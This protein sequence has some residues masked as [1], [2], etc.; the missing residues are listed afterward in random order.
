MSEE[1]VYEQADALQNLQRQT[2]KITLLASEW[3]SLAGGLSTLNRE[4]AINLSQ[5]QNVSV[6]LLVPEGACSDEDKKE[7]KR[8]DISIIEARKCVG[9]DPLVWL[10]HPPENHEIDVIVGHGVKLGSPVQLIK[11]LAQ[12]QNCKWVHVV[13]TVPENLSKHKDYNSA[14]LRGE[15]KHWDEVDL[16]KS[17]DLV[18]PVGPRIAKAYHSYLQ[19]CKKDEEFFE[20]VPGL[21]EREFGDLPAKQKPKEGEDDFIVLL[22]GRGDKEDFELKGYNIAVEAFANKQLKGKHYSLLF[23]GSPEGKQDEVRERLLK[24]GITEEQLTVREFVKSRKRMKELFCEVDMVIM[25]SKEEGFGLVALEALSAGLPILIG[26][27]SGFASAIKNIPL[28]EYS[29]VG[30]S[31]DPAKWA[32]AIKAVRNRH[33]V[34]LG[35]SETLKQ[36]YSEKYCWKKQCE[37]LVDRLLKM[38]Y[39]MNINEDV[40]TQRSEDQQLPSAS[41]KASYD[42]CS[43]HR[44]DTSDAEK[45]SAT[46]ENKQHIKK[47]GENLVKLFVSASV[48]EAGKQKL[49]EEMLALQVLTYAEFQDHSSDRERG[50]GAM[51]E[52]MMQNYGLL[53]KSVH[54]GSL[55]IIFDCQSLEGLDHLWSDYLFGHL[56]KMA[57]QFLLTS[58]MKEKL[59]LR[60]IGLKTTIEKGN[61]LQCRKVLLERSGMNINEDVKTQRSDQQLPSASSKASY[62]SCSLHRSDTSDAE[63]VSA[64]NENKQHIRKVGGMNINEDVKTQ[65]SDQQLPSASSKASYDSCSLHRSDTSDAEKVSATNENKQHIR[66]VGGTSASQTIAANDLVEQGPSVVPESVCQPVSKP[67]QQQPC[68]IEKDGV[69]SGRGK[70]EKVIEEGN[71][72]SPVCSQFGIEIMSEEEVYEQADAVQNPQRQTLKITLLANEWKSS[73]GSL[74]A[75]NR[76]L[77]INLSQIQ[78]VSVSLLVPE[79]TCNDEDKRE[80]E[81]FGISI[82]EARKCVD[83][84][85]LVWLRNPP[86]DHKID[87]IV[88]HGVKLGHQVQHIKAHPQ[89]QN[90]KYVQLAHTAPEDLSKYKGYDS[91]ISRGEKKHW[92]EVA[93]CK[94]A[95]FVVPVGPSFAKAYHSY[96]FLQ[97][98]DQDFFELIPGLFESEFRDLPAKQKP[99]EEKDD[100]IVLLCGRGDKEDFEVKEYKIAVEAFANRRLK[101]KHYSLLFVGSPKGKQDEVRKRLLKYGITEEQLTVRELVKSRE[102]M[103][104]LFCEVD[105]LIMPSKKDGFSLI[106]LEALSAGLP[107]LVGSN[108]GFAKAM[109]NIPFGKYSTVANSDDPARWAEAIEDVRDRHGVVLAESETLKE[110]YSKKYCWKKQCEELVARLW[111]MV[112]GMNINEDVKTQRSDQQLPSASSEASYD[113]CLLHRSDTNDTEKISATTENKQQVKNVGGETKI[114]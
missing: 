64:T 39:G 91:P 47:V 66:K 81:S 75:L 21:F 68:N 20:L 83:L 32:G 78:N 15:K 24:Y 104:E 48:L 3:N 90:C 58:E 76:E 49:L 96:D 28:G 2:L 84:D 35:E 41:S 7:A 9:L 25:P 99:K 56:D 113:S 80:A 79:G 63:K 16:C 98:R 61:Y 5:I 19:E 14:N 53:L 27:N 107:I 87:V 52:A 17:V 31:G 111:K 18:V 106:A 110:H 51:T 30:D 10:S 37:E 43:L 101:G 88:C 8:F 114:N 44:S 93:L 65:R 112:Y 45:V 73:A 97:R 86:Q 11:R 89:F 95:D 34:V 33:K 109:K 40:K 92:D 12:F 59:K 67:M 13:H 82:I 62:D 57:E 94:I 74:S 71:K 55:I 103:K 108:S 54:K 38:V 23:V 4:L 77:A 29:I 105:M 50:V 26:S 36:Y 70:G 85:P 46:N 42:S 100:F 1:E 102:R 6:S 69:I 72:S 22:C 60:T